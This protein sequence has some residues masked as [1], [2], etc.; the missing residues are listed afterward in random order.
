M[1]SLAT[2]ASLAVLAG[3]V[4]IGSPALARVPANPAPAPAQQKSGPRLAPPRA[5][6]AA[7]P[8]LLSRRESVAQ[9]TVTIP[10]KSCAGFVA[11][12]RTWVVTAAHCI[13]EGPQRFDVK[14]R[15]GTVLQ[16]SLAYLDREHDMAALRLD[17]PAPVEPLVL[18]D[19]LPA[20]GEQVLFVGRVDRRSRTQVATVERIDQCPSLPDVSNALF[21]SL[22]ARPGDS[23]APLVDRDLR[24]V[25][26]IH[27]GARCHISAPTLG[28][29]RELAA[30]SSQ[31]A[32]SAPANPAAP[33]PAGPSTGDKVLKRYQA[34]PFVLEKI[35]NGFKFRFSFGWSS[36]SE[37]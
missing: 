26:V 22:E 28:L 16:S 3:A 8:T 37:K 27:G 19:R 32:P 2:L 31:P 18:G 24:V 1:R 5:A 35:P 14:L 15:D 12:E 9:A 20:R 29:A 4:S 36:G 25:G 7:K 10:A 11:H 33:D 30:L 17:Q 34:G 6:Q 23:G 13:P 21:T